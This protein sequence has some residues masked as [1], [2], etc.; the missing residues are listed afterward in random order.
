[1]HSPVQ[2]CV[3]MDCPSIQ[4]LC[5]RCSKQSQDIPHPLS[6]Q[7]VAYLGVSDD[8]LES[9]TRG[10]GLL[11]GP[12]SRAVLTGIQKTEYTEY[13]SATSQTSLLLNA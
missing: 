8:L 1:M 13:S 5:P 12:S 3:I 11:P 10:A 6:K 4:M 2:V 7:W 9:G